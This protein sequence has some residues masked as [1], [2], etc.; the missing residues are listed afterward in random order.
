MDN[1]ITTTRKYA[2]IPEFSDRKEWKK[3]VYDFTINDLEQKID[4]RNKKKQDTSELE[5]QLE[6]IKNGGDFTRSMVNNYTYS[7]VRTAMGEEA[8]RKIIYYHGYFL[9]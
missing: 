6:C 7:L 4:Y 3:R 1:T 8:R 9:K 2:L 5:S